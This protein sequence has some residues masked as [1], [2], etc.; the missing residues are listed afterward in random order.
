ML[1]ETL[2]ILQGN[3]YN[4]KNLAVNGIPEQI[5]IIDPSMNYTV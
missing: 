4:Q 5:Y 3:D 2:L 1:L